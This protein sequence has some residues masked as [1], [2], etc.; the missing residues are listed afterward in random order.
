MRRLKSRTAS[1]FPRTKCSG[2]V[3]YKIVYNK[4]AAKQIALLKSAKLDGKVQNILKLMQQN[5]F[6]SPPSY[7]ALKGDLQ[8]L[9]SRRINVQ[10]R[11]VYQVDE[12][13]K[14]IRILSMW[15]HYEA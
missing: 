9:F 1:S 7:E 3:M 12:A 14:I 4:K 8:G 2:E 13:N 15:T 5:P 11:L 6:A 10:H